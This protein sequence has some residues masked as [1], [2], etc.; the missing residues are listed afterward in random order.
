MA[1]IITYLNN[2]G[3]TMCRLLVDMINQLAPC[4]L[5]SYAGLVCFLSVSLSVS[6]AGRANS[7]FEKKINF[8]F[9]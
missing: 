8:L 7:Y 2:I 1:S 6:L 9:K 4:I 5:L 3:Q